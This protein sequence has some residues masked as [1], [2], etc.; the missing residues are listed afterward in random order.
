MQRFEGHTNRALPCGI[1][2]SPCGRFLAAA[3]ED[4]A[5]SPILIKT[6]MQNDIASCAVTFLENQQLSSVDLRVDDQ[7]HVV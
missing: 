5:V 7:L 4:R 3:S 1:D 2:V 6:C